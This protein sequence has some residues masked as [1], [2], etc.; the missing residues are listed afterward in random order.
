MPASRWTFCKSQPQH[1]AVCVS[2]QCVW[3]DPPYKLPPGT[4]KVMV[5]SPP[6]FVVVPR[7]R[8]LTHVSKLW[9]FAAYFYCKCSWCFFFQQASVIE[10]L[11]CT[12][13]F[14]YDPSAHFLA[15]GNFDSYFEN[16]SNGPSPSL[17]K[18]LLW[19]IIVFRRSEELRISDLRNTSRVYIL[20]DMYI[21]CKMSY[22][23]IYYTHCVILLYNII[24]YNIIL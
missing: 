21:T 9:C 23:Y 11:S 19:I 15:V 3:I 7:N 14:A 5:Q 13:F 1:N 6:G 10:L 12:L 18:S 4:S 24:K 16:L 17:F 20:S 2:T 8:V 22:I